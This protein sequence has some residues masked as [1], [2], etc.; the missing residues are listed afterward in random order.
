MCW[1]RRCVTY[2]KEKLK[3]KPND[4]GFCIFLVYI[5]CFWMRF[6]FICHKIWNRIVLK[7]LNGVEWLTI[8]FW[9]KKMRWTRMSSQ[10]IMTPKNYLSHIKN[11]DKIWKYIR[12]HLIWNVRIQCIKKIYKTKYKNVK[13]ARFWKIQ[14]TSNIQMFWQNL[15]IYSKLQCSPETFKSGIF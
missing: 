13:L 10:K 2:L 14:K 1:C 6:C 15:K 4:F 7:M 9:R 12:K 3:E 11:V 5:F 8:M